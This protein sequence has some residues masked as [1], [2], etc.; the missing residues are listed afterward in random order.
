MKDP[1]VAFGC[2]RQPVSNSTGGFRFFDHCGLS[3]FSNRFESSRVNCLV[4]RDLCAKLIYPN[5]NTAGGRLAIPTAHPLRVD[6]RHY[7]FSE[8]R[9]IGD[10]NCKL[11]ST[12]SLREVGHRRNFIVNDDIS[13][14]GEFV[15]AGILIAT[16]IKRLLAGTTIV[17]FEPGNGISAGPSGAANAGTGQLRSPSSQFRYFFN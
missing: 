3:G 15:F 13:L 11:L 5:G 10:K 17:S 12:V 8:H 14:R 16:V 9:G 6:L 4:A 1:K 7:G 2:A